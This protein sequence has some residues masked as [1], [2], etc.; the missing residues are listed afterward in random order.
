MGG[1]RCLKLRCERWYYV[2]DKPIT[3]FLWL[4]PERSYHC[5]KEQ[6]RRPTPIGEVTW[7][8]MRVEA[9]QEPVPG[10]WLPAKV[11]VDQYDLESMRDKKLVVA[12]RTETS[13]ER[14]E[15][16]PKQEAAFFREVAIPAD[17]PTFTIKDGA[18][19]GSASPEPVGARTKQQEAQ[20][21]RRPRP[22]RGAALSRA[23]RPG[24]L[25]LSPPPCGPLHGRRH[26]RDLEGRTLG[27][28]RQL[29]IL[30]L[31]RDIT[32]LQPASARRSRKRKPLT[33]AGRGRSTSSRLTAK[34][35]S[36]GRRCERAAEARPR[37]GTTAYRCFGRTLF[38]AATTGC[39]APWPTCWSR[40]GTTK[41]TSTPCGFASNT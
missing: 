7:H 10:V 2:D 25:A 16:S 4:C 24:P 9:F 18:L 5:V 34:T 27:A 36:A 20:A 39:M 23:G 31:P 3:Q 11:V 41:S 19:D 35:C 28:A 32:T 15:L 30:H 13:V 37:A 21:S 17:L 14:A 1:L 38:S 6:L 33:A 12:Q 29:G 40:R 26:H 8:E 22:R